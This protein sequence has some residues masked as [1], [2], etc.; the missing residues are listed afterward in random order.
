M[1][2]S[3]SL[4]GQRESDAYHRGWNDCQRFIAEQQEARLGKKAQRTS[5]A[6]VERNIDSIRGLQREVLDALQRNPLGLTDFDLES[7]LGRTHQSV[8]AARNALM[9]AGLVSDSGKTRPNARGNHSIVWVL[10]SPSR[11]E[12]DDRSDSPDSGSLRDALPPRHPLAD[13]YDG[14]D[15]LDTDG[16]LW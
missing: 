13:V 1:E 2:H 10:T 3:D 6:A 5:R 16:S 12:S 4:C 14:G 8:S 7:A 11:M 15:I 9:T